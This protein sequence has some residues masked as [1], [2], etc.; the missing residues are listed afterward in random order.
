MLEKKHKVEF[1]DCDFASRIKMNVLFELFAEVAT[2]DA[3]QTGLWREDLQGQ[4]GWI[5]T[6]QTLKLYEDICLGD[7]ITITTQ[8]MKPSAVIF[9]RYYKIL[10]E[11]KLIG[12]CFS[13]WT[14]F[15]L[16]KRRVIRPKSVGIVI[17][18]LTEKMTPPERLMPLEEESGQ[19]YHVRYS[20]IDMNGH[21]NNTQYIRIAYDLLEMDYLKNHR[22]CEL[23]INYEKEVPPC[24]ALQ[25]A[26]KREKDTFMIEGRQEESCFLIRLTFRE[27]HDHD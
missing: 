23:S 1:R 5:V 14:L 20:D 17:P 22:L 13:Q 3:L 26:M 4:C 21:L 25:L 10:K 24:T 15:D 18:E 7:E 19:T 27:A 12:E 8:Y 16:V 9:P 2:A 6:K 11:G